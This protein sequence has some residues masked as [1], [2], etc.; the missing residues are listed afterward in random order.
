MSPPPLRQA[1]V[2]ASSSVKTLPDRSCVA[3]VCHLSS[4]VKC[5]LCDGFF[6]SPTRATLFFVVVVAFNFNLI[7]YSVVSLFLYFRFFFS[8]M[9]ILSEKVRVLK[10]KTNICVKPNR[11][12]ERR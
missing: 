7:Q 3:L 10:C 8:L 6:F 2:K 11:H 1:T 12:A 5:A 4:E 9:F